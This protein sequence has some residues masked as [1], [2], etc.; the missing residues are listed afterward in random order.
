MKT[1]WRIL[2]YSRHYPV[3]ALVAFILTAVATVL[4]LALPA[5]TQRFFDVVIAEERYDLIVPTALMAIGAIFLRQLSM[6]AQGYLNTGF[7]QRIVHDLRNGLYEKIQ[8]LPMRWFDKQ[9]TG[10][11]MTRVGSDVPAIERVIVEGIS[12]GLSGVLQLVIVLAYMFSMHFGMT[13]I[14]LAPMPFV[15]LATW[16]YSRKN[17]A[18]Y[19]EAKEASSELN[20]LLHDN[21]AG[22]RQI[23]AYTVEPEE[24]ERFS[25][26]S[27]VVHRTQ[28]KVAKANAMTWPAV[29][30]IAESGIALMMGAASYW[31]LTGELTPGEIGAF[32]FLW[33]YLYD[34]ISRINTLTQMFVGGVVAGKRV[35]SI[36][37]MDDEKNLEEGARPDS[38]RGDVVFEKVSFSYDGDTPVVKQ[39]SLEAKSGQ[40]VA[41]VGPTGA[42]KSTL[43]NLLTRFYECGEGRI[44][45]DGRP[46]RELSKEWLRDR[47]GYVTQES[48]LFNASIR[49]NLL[50]AKREASDEELW[51]ALRA[52]NA[53]NFVRELAEGIDTITGERGTR[54]S[55]GE[56]QRISIARALLKNPPI[57]LLDEATSAVDNETE[58]LIQEA[59]M[60]LRE[61]R[62]CFVIA[63]RLTTVREADLICVLEDGAIVERGTHEELLEEGRLYAKL[64]SVGFEE[65]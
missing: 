14:T 61:N 7:G 59:L 9:A 46:V 43:L 4:V 54:L 19:R 42:G 15:A 18:R 33:G 50:L 51:G 64:C 49:D 47:I 57:L 13:L 56:R 2:G 16:L 60:N 22:I 52:A 30:L 40:T 21:I 62:T 36:L 45:V 6:M 38:F 32:L 23:K 48:F 35:F 39:V 55:G 37:D 12:Q 24:L 34:P 3:Q 53:E 1:L 29:S 17:E 63:H 11:I 27:G 28:M 20:S 58:R 44:L 25:E 26:S 8:R 5:M 65:A 31:V 41:L 10:D